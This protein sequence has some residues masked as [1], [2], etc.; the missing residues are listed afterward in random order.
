MRITEFPLPKR[1]LVHISDTHLLA[2]DG[3][4]YDRVDSTAHLRCLLAE[5][6]TSGVRPDAFIFTGDIADKGESDAYAAAREAV[7]PVAARL[8][9]ET[10]W[11]MGN[12]DDRESFRTGL[13]DQF[14]DTQPVDEV[15]M[16]GG[17]RIIALDT[18][19]PGEHY[20][21]ISDGQLDWLRGVL[22]TPVP[23]GSILAMHHPPIPSML[24]LAASVELRDHRRLSGALSG[25]DVRT[26]IAGHLHYSSHS[27]FAGIPVSVASASCYTQ[28]LNVPVGGTR[29][30]DGA[31]A[32]N[33]IHVY[34]DV[35]LH[36]VVPVGETPAL[37]YVSKEET[38]RL[39]AKDGVIRRS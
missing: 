5:L 1:T 23:E 22:A 27:T 28:D 32:F 36:S 21:E 18:S 6:E 37:S 13:L 15:R 8:G 12:H 3:K 24:H 4:L 7:A 31:R 33:L 19:V 11:V 35:I 20:G 34:D 30:R 38:D 9:A 29:G 14:P 17:L 2:G 39:L 26:I 25:G 10:I 16:I